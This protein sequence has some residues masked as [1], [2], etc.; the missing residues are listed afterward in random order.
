MTYKADDGRH[1]LMGVSRSWKDMD[2]RHSE[3]FRAP[4]LVRSASG[5][6]P[7]RAHVAHRAVTGQRPGPHQPPADPLVPY[8]SK[9]PR[10][11]RLLP[12][13]PT[14]DN[15]GGGGGKGGGGGGRISPLLGRQ[16]PH[17]GGGLSPFGG[18]GLHPA[19]N[20]ALSATMAATRGLFTRESER[21]RK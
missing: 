20:I 7:P 21:E 4:E 11:G 17:S 10:G 16:S 18:W 8:K 3:Q 9:Q 2:R 1:L 13:L 19:A 15:S 5:D 14:A 6:M 12:V